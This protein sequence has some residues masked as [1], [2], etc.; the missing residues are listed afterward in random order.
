[1][2]RRWTTA[3]LTA[4]LAILVA[5]ALPVLAPKAQADEA[6]R[7]G[8]GRGV[9]VSVIVASTS[10]TPTVTATGTPRPSPGTSSARPGNGDD[11]D[12]QGNGGQGGN[13]QGGNQNDQGGGQPSTPDPSASQ[14]STPVAEPDGAGGLS[15]DGTLYVSG[16]ILVHKASLNPLRGTLLL[17]LT[18]RNVSAKP[19]DATAV[20]WVTQIFG[21]TIGSPI[22][23]EIPG[24]QPDE[25]RPVEVT[26]DGVG[27][28]TFVTGHATL[29]K[30]TGD[31]ETPV[32]PV[33]R[34]MATFTPPWFVLVLAALGGVAALVHRQRRSARRT[35]T[36]KPAAVVRTPK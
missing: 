18:V 20:F 31:G 26:I 15:E 17:R 33:N 25:T 5:A 6:D 29:T 27:Q 14:T 23:V 2:T 24:L 32:A 34:D 21:G 35:H 36:S 22:T 9:G 3:P 7:E 28:W 30:K 19:A 16:L 8:G 1:M 13:S 10:P 11:N 4:S 12:D